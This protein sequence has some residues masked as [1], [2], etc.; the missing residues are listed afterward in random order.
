METRD[1]ASTQSVQRA[2][3]L[4]SLFGAPCPPDG[5]RR[6]RWTVT[7]MARA[8]GLHKSV[9]GRL[10]ATMARSGFVI[11]DPTTRAYTVGPEAFAVGRAYEPYHA[12][13]E[14]AR[15]R[16]EALTA[17]CGHASYLGVRAGNGVMYIVAVDSSRSIR[18]T[19]QPGERN[20]FHAGA[21]GKVL[22]S[23]MSDAEARARLG[24]G[25]LE[26]LT[27][28]TLTDP[29]VV[30]AEVDQARLTGIAFNRDESIVGA[31]SI[32][33]GI[34]NH[35]GELIAGLGIVYPTHIV[36]DD[37]LAALIPLVIRAAADIS[38]R[39]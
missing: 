12:L 24:P 26:S 39:I 33:A 34:T 35:D 11:Q 27:A 19:I 25:P 18:V 4:L 7:D 37:D 28:A 1:A 31:G 32:A 6:T 21:I 15:P 13:N 17:E 36:T 8:T 23:G 30:M 14:A 20:P 22:L 16:M 3:L 2:L 10:M 29:N 9:V 5:A 38:A